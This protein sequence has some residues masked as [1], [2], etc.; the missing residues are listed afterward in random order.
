MRIIRILLISACF[1]EVLFLFSSCKKDNINPEQIEEFS[2]HS[3]NTGSV[4]RVWVVLPEDYNPDLIYETVYLLDAQ[5]FYLRYDKIAKITKEQSLKFNKQNVI[6][7]GISS[8]NDRTRDFTPS[9]TTFG[10]GG[11][12]KY[13]KFLEFELIPKIESDYTVDTTAKSRLI[14]GHSFG[15]LLASYLFIK[16][17]HIF[18]NYLMLS[19]SLWYDNEILLRQEPDFR[20]QNATINNLVFIGCGEME[21]VIVL[22]AQ[23][24]N[25]R[26]STYYPNCKLYFHKVIY[27]AHIGSALPDVEKGLEFYFKNK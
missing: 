14:I 26:L 4:Y 15:G 17:N 27:K 1:M 23:E 8:K 13:S 2:I 24:W 9:P 16:Q 12:D 25:Y 6:V 19:P 21:E 11:S 22:G 18:Y 7:V 20:E 5:T 3:D 10:D